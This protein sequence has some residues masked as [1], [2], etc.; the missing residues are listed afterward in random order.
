MPSAMNKHEDIA[1][2]LK[3]RLS[4]LTSRVAEIDT[5]FANRYLLIPKTKQLTSKIKMRSEALSILDFRK[6]DRLKRR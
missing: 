6:S 1:K 5:S 3:A 2:T 4:E